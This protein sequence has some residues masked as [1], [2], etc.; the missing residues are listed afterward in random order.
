MPHDE[1]PVLLRV[2]SAYWTP[3]IGWAVLAILCIDLIVRA[4]WGILLGYAPTV[5]LIAWG[6]YALL[7][8]PAITVGREA[9]TVRNIWV[10]TVLPYPRIIDIAVT[11][12][13]RLT[14]TADDG[15][16][17]TVTS[18]N[19]PGLPKLSTAYGSP[20]QADRLGLRRNHPAP[21]RRD[22]A[23]PQDLVGPSQVLLDAWQRGL[24]APDA[25]ATRTPNWLVI[26]VT[27][28][29]TALAAYTWLS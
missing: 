28:V 6:L 8:A 2:S 24:T 25:P 10:T 15:R 26:T 23:S 21:V 17:R 7:W 18:W 3:I 20:R 9:A 1:R 4:E 11:I 16:E 29:L 22:A 5:A 13:V 19:A 12:M 27:A 14:Y